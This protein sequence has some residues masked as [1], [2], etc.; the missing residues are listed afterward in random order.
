MSTAQ[1]FRGLALLAALAAMA[2]AGYWW[3][4]RQGAGAQ[5]TAADRVVAAATAGLS[6]TADAGAK[7]GRK[8]LYYRN[9]MGLP[10]KSP[11]PK[12]DPMGMDYI[13][14][15][16]DD[17]PAAGGSDIK[18]S[19]DRVQKLGVRTEPASKRVL[20]RIVRAS[21]RVEVDERRVFAIAPKFDGWIERLHV[22][23][24]GQVVGAG[25]ALFEV[26]SPELV[27]AQREYAVAQTGVTAL[28]EASPEAQASM[29]SLADS[30]LTRLRNWDISEAQIRELAVSGNARRTLTLRS[31]VNG[32]VLEKKALQG[33]RFMPGEMLYQIADLSTVWVLADVF[34]Q[35]LALVRKGAL[36]QVHINALPERKIEGRVTFVYPTLSAQTRTVPVRI[37][38]SNRDGALKPAM[39]ADVTIN[40]SAETP[41]LAVPNSAV[42][43][44]GTRRVVL[45]Q[46]S[47]G[48]F[49]SREVKLGARGHEY[50][51]VLDG[52]REGEDVVVTAN[53][54]IDSESNLRAALGGL[55]GTPKPAAIS[56]RASGTVEEIDAKG[57]TLSITHG[58]VASLKWPSMTMEFAVGNNAL[59]K[60]LNPGTAIAF[61]FVERQPGEWVIVSLERGKAAP[62][63]KPAAK[64]Q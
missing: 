18:I 48:R 20:H 56:H 31:P 52:V 45:V 38:L 62:A 22:N 9:P 26:Y 61:E 27:S 43:D 32:I 7:P 5:D 17:A 10:D 2:A 23:S 54:L 15:Y 53:F 50:V 16:E 1:V 41:R 35:D 44:S 63:T 14:V 6:A 39:F 29:K 46:T 12:K 55:N 58:P 25:Q 8:V 42:I 36:A 51:E 47:E 34:E 64:K 57:N 13:A 60:G 40:V 21:G 30:S 49:D 3:G 19:P 37:E 24:T 33:M 11:T 59:L 4:Q 28:K